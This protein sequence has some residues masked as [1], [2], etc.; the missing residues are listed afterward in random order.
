ILENRLIQ[1]TGSREILMGDNTES[2]YFIFTLYQVLLTGRLRD[3]QLVDYLYHLRFHGREALTRDYSVRIAKLTT[4]N[5]QIH[6]KIN[7]V[8]HVW[9]NQAYASPDNEEAEKMI[10]EAL[11]EDAFK[12]GTIKKPIVVKGGLGFAVHALDVGLIDPDQ[13]R[14]V[15]KSMEGRKLGELEL[16]QAF[17][18]TIVKSMPWTRYS[19]EQVLGYA[20]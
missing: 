8:E 14:A 11:P 9:I 12:W 16:N 7:P 17:L 18:E 13:F 19:A 4:E 15:W 20:V 2:D 1:P 10:R 3:D 6:G 5:L